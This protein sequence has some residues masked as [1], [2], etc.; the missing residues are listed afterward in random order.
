MLIRSGEAR[1]VGWSR[2]ML[3]SGFNI[4]PR[5][6]IRRQTGF[7]ARITRTLSCSASPLNSE[8]QKLTPAKKAGHLRMFAAL[9]TLLAGFGG[10]FLMHHFGSQSTQFQ[11]LFAVGF[12]AVVIISSVA[13]LLILTA[14]KSQCPN[15]GE[16][17][18]R[19]SYKD[20]IEYLSCSECDFSEPT[21]YV[22]SES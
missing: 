8:D 22:N 17:S 19:M 20:D 11:M 18:C 2:Q 7:A 21:G 5:S 13:F 16:R 14:W 6:V 1:L 9:L 3:Y 12:F 15:C 10:A 4:L